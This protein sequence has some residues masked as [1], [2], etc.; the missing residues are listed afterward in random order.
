LNVTTGRLYRFIERDSTN[1]SDIPLTNASRHFASGISA[2][3]LDI[4]GLDYAFSKN[5]SGRYWYDD[6]DDVCRQYLFFLM[7]QHDLG[8][9]NLK[10]DGRVFISGDTD[11]VRAGK[12]DNRAISLMSTY[13]I[14]SYKWVLGFQDMHGDTAMSYGGMYPASG[15]FG[16]A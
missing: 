7:G 10:H 1:T 6:L 13:S 15:Q 12:I 2:D 8:N 3:Y 9:G 5:L 14:A 11:P 4:T 16:A